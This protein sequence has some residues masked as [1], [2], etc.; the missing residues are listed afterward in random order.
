MLSHEKHGELIEKPVVG[1]STVLLPKM[2]GNDLHSTSVQVRS[3]NCNSPPQ[4]GKQ[5]PR[6]SSKGKVKLLE[7]F[8][9]LPSLLH[10]CIPGKSKLN[11]W[12]LS[13]VSDQA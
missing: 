6:L 8:S 3:L 5:R 7:I 12:R 10:D 9:D 2:G 1:G 4:A 13:D 11:D